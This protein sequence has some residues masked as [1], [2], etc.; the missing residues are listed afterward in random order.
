MNF[1]HQARKDKF[2]NMQCFLQAEEAVS[3]AKAR[4]REEIAE[5]E[6]AQA[7]AQKEREEA[8]AAR[9]RAEREIRE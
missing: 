2:K 6:N 5:A 9:K 7:A 3:T 8:I 4:L 1:I